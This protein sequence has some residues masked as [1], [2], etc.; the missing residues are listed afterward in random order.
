MKPVRESVLE[1][2]RKATFMG[3]E[4]ESAAALA[5]LDASDVARLEVPLSEKSSL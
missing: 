4:V 2:E 1:P 5:P 3:S